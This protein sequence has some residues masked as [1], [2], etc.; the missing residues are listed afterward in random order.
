MSRPPSPPSEPLTSELFV[1]RTRIAAP[2][3]DVFGWHARPGALER[4]TPP[5]ET[6]EVLEKH[7]GIE[8]GARVVL[9][10]G[11][12]PLATR[13]VAEH[14]DYVE[15]EQFRDVQVAGPFARW[16]HTHR[17]TPDGADACY[18][19]DCI[20]YT[21]P[22]GAMGALGGGGMVRRRLGRM[23]EYR[24]RVTA[25]DIAAHKRAGGRT[26][27]VLV[28]GASG[29]IGS[30]LIPLLTTGGH[31]VVRLVRNGGTR[32]AGTVQWDPATGTI[33]AAALEG[34]DAVVHLAGE[35]IAG[36]WT[37]EKKARIYGSRVDGTKAL[38]RALTALARPPKVLIAASAIGYYG[39]RGADI[40]DEDSAPGAGFLA[41]VVREWEA[42]T[43][44][45]AALGIRVVNLRFGVVLSSAGG[46]LATMLPPFRLGAGGPVGSGEQYMSWVALDDAIGAILHALTTSELSGPVNVVAPNPATNREFTKTLGRVLSRPTVI[47]MP[48]F[49][50]KLAF[51]EMGEALL[52]GSTRVE[53]HRLK[54]TVYPFRFP[55]L[56]GALRHVLG[57]PAS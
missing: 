29:L 41:D 36:R 23:F 3:A 17:V 5:W 32:R 25:Q 45:A 24:H 43:Q 22:F 7:G 14:R 38:V 40:V 55:E 31:D 6:V 27:M 46:A 34:I 26:M 12:G 2:A 10:M 13:W 16:E 49:A 35:N 52:L 4:L 42:A 48:A 30:A 50:V 57:K 56:E 18:L 8:N 33:D 51:G 28:T 19:E 47:P 15:G 53:A 20:E 9:R 1:R 37:A 11:S 21:L 39:D 54:E 44:P